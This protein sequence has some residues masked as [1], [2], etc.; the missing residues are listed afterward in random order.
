VREAQQPVPLIL[1]NR[2]IVQSQSYE[3]IESVAR[4]L[5]GTLLLVVFKPLKRMCRMMIAPPANGHKILVYGNDSSLLHTRRLVL[6]SAGFEVDTVSDLTQFRHF[7]NS[8]EPPYELFILCHTV[9]E[10]E[11]RQIGLIAVDRRVGL[12]QLERMEPP[13]LLVDTTSEIMSDRKGGRSSFSSKMR[14]IVAL[15]MLTSPPYCLA[16]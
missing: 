1:V 6:A 5:M 14:E 11:R 2:R 10:A 7:A 8:A 16:A 4:R 13:P 9:T 12:Y 15:Q 3:R